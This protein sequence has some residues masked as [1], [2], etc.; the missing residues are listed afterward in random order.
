MYGRYVEHGFRLGPLGLRT[1][2]NRFGWGV[3]AWVG[4]LSVDLSWD[5]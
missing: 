3:T 4:K 5:K 2:S 1:F